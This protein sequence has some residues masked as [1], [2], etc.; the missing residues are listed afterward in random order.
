MATKKNKIP[1]LVTLAN[2]KLLEQLNDDNWNAIKFTLENLDEHF[3]IEYR[4][5]LNA[6]FKT[7]AKSIESYDGITNKQK[8]QIIFLIKTAFDGQKN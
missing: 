1:Q 5:L 6:L 8:I 3:S 4:E 7:V 2:K